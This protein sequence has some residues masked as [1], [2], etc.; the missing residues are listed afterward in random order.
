MANPYP[1]KSIVPEWFSGANRYFREVEGL[2]KKFVHE[3]GLTFKGCPALLDIFLNGYI[4]VT[5]CDIHVYD[6][7]GIKKVSNRNDADGCVYIPCTYDQLA[8]QQYDSSLRCQYEQPA[9]L[10]FQH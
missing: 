5:P 3:R 1:A 2:D 10:L 4:L 9:S 7:N 6:E 8:H